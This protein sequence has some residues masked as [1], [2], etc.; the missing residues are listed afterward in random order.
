M[1]TYLYDLPVKC[2]GFIL[3]DPY[4]DEESIILNAR[5]TNEANKETY[6]HEIYHKLVG[7]LDSPEDINVIENRAHKR[8]LEENA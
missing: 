6:V 2:R 5:L 4:T 3:R 7:D 1:R 8:R